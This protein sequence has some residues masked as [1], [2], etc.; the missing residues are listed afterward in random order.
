[1]QRRLDHAQG[2][3]PLQTRFTHSWESTLL[4]LMLWVLADDH[5]AALALDDLAFFTNRLYRWSDFHIDCSFRDSPLGLAAPSNP[6]ACEIIWGH[7][8]RDF[9]PR[10]NLNEVH[11]KLA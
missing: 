3:Q 7:F 11:S 8:H 5:N 6:A 4:L 1:M 9:I 10:Q 2:M